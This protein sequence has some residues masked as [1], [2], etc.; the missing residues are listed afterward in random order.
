MQVE[1][2]MQL[3]VIGDGSGTAPIRPARLPASGH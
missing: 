2:V 1:H 3:S